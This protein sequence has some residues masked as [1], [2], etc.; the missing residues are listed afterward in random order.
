MSEDFPMN[1]AVVIVNSPYEESIADDEDSESITDSM[2]DE[3]NS[4]F[5]HEEEESTTDTL[6][7][8]DDEES[9]VSDT[10]NQY[11]LND[12]QDFVENK[13][14][15]NMEDTFPSENTPTMGANTLL[16]PTGLLR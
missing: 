8:K 6:Y 11:E 9:L 16:N 14:D 15:S 1:D 2:I 12:Q 3:E 4:K 13:K 10:N 5:N 7:C